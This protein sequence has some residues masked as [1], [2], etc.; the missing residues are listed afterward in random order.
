MTDLGSTEKARVIASV[1]FSERH[2][3]S[4]VPVGARG[5][6]LTAE[7]SAHHASTPD[8]A[9]ARPA[10]RPAPHPAPHPAPLHFSS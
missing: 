3:S 1:D 4:Q 10:P 9:P 2:V 6:R 8:S 5:A 7:L